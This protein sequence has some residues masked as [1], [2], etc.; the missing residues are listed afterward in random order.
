ASTTPFSTG[1]TLFFAFSP[2]AWHTTH[3][4]NTCSPFAGSSA[5]A[6]MLA[7]ANAAAVSRNGTSLLFMSDFSCLCGQ[8]MPCRSSGAGDCSLPGA[9][10]RVFDVS[11][12]LID[13]H[14]P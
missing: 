5:A 3:R 8:W 11:L 2:T 7:T 10:Q 13:H 12:D 9:K 4:L 6:G 1:P 14:Q